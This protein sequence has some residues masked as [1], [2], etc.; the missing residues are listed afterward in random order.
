MRDGLSFSRSLITISLK[1]A[2]CCSLLM[3][4]SMLF[5][6]ERGKVEVVKDPK[7]DSL[8]Q[9]Y[10]VD[11]KTGPLP[12]LPAGS[13][14]QVSTD[15]YRVQIYAGAQR[16]AAYD[17]QAKFQERFPDQ[18]TYIS[19]SEPYFKVHVGDFRTRLE[20]EKMEHDLK[21]WFSGMFIVSEKITPKINT[22]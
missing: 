17:A 6:Q 2:A 7:V 4:P 8:I 18:R 11:K 1:F 9:D 19:Y 16:Q 20:A 5:A 22:E 3:L 13:A 15:G 10:L 21:A 12:N 14:V